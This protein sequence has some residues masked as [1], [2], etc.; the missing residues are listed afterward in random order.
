[1][2]RSCGAVWS[3][4]VTLPESSKLDFLPVEQFRVRWYSSASQTHGTRKS[5]RLGKTL[6]SRSA[7]P[8]SRD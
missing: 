5:Y 7:F 1:M 4:A 2:P 6:K 3:V 8:A